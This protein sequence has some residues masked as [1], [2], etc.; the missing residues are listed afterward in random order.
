MTR[1][2]CIFLLLLACGTS[3]PPGPGT[4]ALEVPVRGGTTTQARNARSFQ[5]SILE[6]NPV[7]G[8]KVANEDRLLE[9]LA[10]ELSSGADLVVTPEMSNTGYHFEDRNG[11]AAMV[12]PIPGPFT[13]RLSALA[14]ATGG[15][16]V[17]SMP[18]VDPDT[19][20]YYIAAVLV[21]PDG[22]VGTYRKNHLWQQEEFW[23]AQGDLGVPVFNTPLG[24]I[25]INICMDVVFWETPRL[26]AV[27]GADIL[28]VPTNSSGQTVSLMPALAAQ[29]GIYVVGANRAGMEGDYH[30]PG[31]SGVWSP[32]GEPL[33]VSPY[34]PP[35]QSLV[36]TPT[37]VVR[38]TVDPSRA[39]R[40]RQLILERRRPELYADVAFHA[41]RHPTPPREERVQLLALQLAPAAD[42]STA[43]DALD[44][45][46]HDALANRT[47]GLPVLA[48]TPELFV[49]GPAP[50]D[51]S[52][53]L[54]QTNAATESL[55]RI[56][57]RH[58][59]A[60]ITGAVVDT[61][62]GPSNGAVI[63]SAEGQVVGRYAKT[64]LEGAER[65]W[66]RAGDRIGVFDVEGLGR[67]GVLV[68]SE[69]RV[70]EL[71]GSLAVAR[72]DVIAIPAALEAD[73]ARYLSVSTQLGDGAYGRPAEIH[74]DAVA[75]FAQAYVVA[76]NYAGDGFAGHSAVLGI[77]PIYGLDRPEVAGSSAAAVLASIDLGRASQWWFDQQHLIVLRR[78]PLY[79]ALLRGAARR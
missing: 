71:A 22:V 24:R 64:H 55:S 74:W 11:I 61:G 59:V 25:A 42:A 33:A 69:A 28:V 31:L 60:L 70:P 6:F 5:V 26:A 47:Q 36:G 3:A 7:L 57:S 46:L 53:A 44:A 13:S 1:I 37:R 21:G 14:G 9:E 32:G 27:G 30:M 66:A 29:N 48:V 62:Q 50:V 8:D 78:P 38:A 10:R 58:G 39:A 67:V 73:D 56:A 16:I 76:A 17:T 35:S 45:A 41:P 23:A 4:S 51:P 49:G 18:E 52:V 72:V 43:L 68:G 54:R 34:L 20:L 75:R 15:H 19:G 2:C 40:H 65:T 77:D 63:L 79:R 12:E